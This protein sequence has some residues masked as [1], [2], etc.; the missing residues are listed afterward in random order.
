MIPYR[1]FFRVSAVWQYLVFLSIA[2]AASGQ[3]SQVILGTTQVQ[4]SVDNN[5]PGMAEAF[6]VMANA[7][8]QIASFTVFLDG[9]NSAATVWVGL[10]TNNHYGH[11]GKLLTQAAILNPIAG[12][13]NTITVPAVQVSQGVSYW[14]ALL[15]TGGT[16]QF[17]DSNG[18]CSSQ[19]SQQTSLTTLPARWSTGQQWGT[20]VI[21]MAATGASGGGTVSVTVTPG[22]ASL[23]TSQ[24][25][26][27]SATVS[28]TTN[29][30][31]NWSTSGGTVSSG[32][33][34]TAPTTAGT[35]SVTATSLADSTKSASSVVTV[36]Q[37]TQVTVSVSPSSTML[38]PNGQ[39]QFTAYVW[40]TSNTAVT[41]KVSGGSISS[42]GLYTAPSTSGTYTIKAVSA[43]QTTQSGS[44][45]AT[46]SSPAPT[47]TITVGV[48]PST[49]TLQPRAQ[50]Q[51]AATV[52]GT[53]NTA[54]TWAVTQGTGTITSG[55]LYTAPQTA[56]TDVITATSQANGTTSSSATAV[57][58]QPH[59]VALTWLPSTSTNIAYYNVYR[60]TILGGPYSVI[61]T[62][63]TSTAYTDSNVQSGAT[64]YYVTTAVD[65]T[66]VE[67]GQSAAAQAVIPSP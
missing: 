28:G 56:E 16:V 10:Y 63:V 47:P 46:V 21:S 18:G 22:S 25:K 51:F 66:G 35:Y 19:T 42:S 30:W 39:Q 26:Q 40:N 12:S 5:A 15:G 57:I 36:S 52:S 60:G 65:T 3:T 67:S 59:S 54:V 11:P 33:M 62:G 14:I 48:S 43:A 1:C 55:G 7:S 37:P 64:Y 27:F 44:A 2:L 31:V 58:S 61:K 32:G 6:P 49:A 8:G 9:S 23:Q 53:T 50:Q 38:Q 13:W 29:T 45:M 20:C 41:W 17:R 34:Y 4:S 24:Q